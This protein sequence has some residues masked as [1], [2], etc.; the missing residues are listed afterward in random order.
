MRS[1][2]FAVLFLFYSGLAFSQEVFLNCE[3][4]GSLYV[5]GLT[6]PLDYLQYIIKLDKSN[7]A[8]AVTSNQ[9][10]IRGSLSESE[11]YYE[12]KGD[13]FEGKINRYNLSYT[14]KY[15]AYAIFFSSGYCKKAESLL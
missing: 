2:L 6:K 14:L 4:A 11:M 3:G 1:F 13:G 15:T 5:D 7:G 10:T 12:I 9:L 8:S